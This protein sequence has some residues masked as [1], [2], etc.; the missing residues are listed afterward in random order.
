MINNGT[1]D[2]LR[3]P[4]ITERLRKNQIFLRCVLKGIATGKIAIRNDDAEFCLIDGYI[5]LA[6][7]DFPRCYPF[8]H[9][10]VIVGIADTPVLLLLRRL[11]GSDINAVRH[12]QF[13]YVSC[14]SELNLPADGGI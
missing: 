7:V 9:H 3:P 1:Y 10:P 6:Q 5:A 11:I 8:S 2:R 12:L 4:D 14:T 13:S